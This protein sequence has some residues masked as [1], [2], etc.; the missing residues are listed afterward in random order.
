MLLYGPWNNEHKS[1]RAI[2]VLSG[3]VQKKNVKWQLL[4]KMYVGN[5]DWKVITKHSLVRVVGSWVIFTL[6]MFKNALLLHGIL[7]LRGGGKHSGFLIILQFKNH[8]QC[9][10]NS[11][12]V[13]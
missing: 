11:T 4:K 10:Q 9:P 12:T 1:Y 8:L 7:N 6:Q 5:K 3:K 13:C 2:F